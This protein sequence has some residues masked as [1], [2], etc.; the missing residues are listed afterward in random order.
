ME[1]TIDLLIR[2]TFTDVNSIEGADPMN[3]VASYVGH[4]SN[5]ELAAFS[6]S[7]A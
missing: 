4:K 2:H 6:R 3:D 1:G 7:Q 5:R